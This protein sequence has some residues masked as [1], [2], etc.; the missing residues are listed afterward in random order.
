MVSTIGPQLRVEEAVDQAAR[1]EQLGEVIQRRVERAAR[2]EREAPVHG[3]RAKRRRPARAVVGR[4]DL[5]AARPAAQRGARFGHGLQPA[6][7]RLGLL[8]RFRPKRERWLV[9]ERCGGLRGRDGPAAASFA[10]C[11]CRSLMSFSTWSIGA[12]PSLRPGRAVA[13]SVP[14]SRG[15]AAARV[16]HRAGRK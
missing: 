4:N 11:C 2:H 3:E 16:R 10:I 9:A 14:R 13:C 7:K 1:G 15:R 8:A 5:L 12:P 6:A